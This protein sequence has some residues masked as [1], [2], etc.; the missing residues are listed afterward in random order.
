MRTAVSGTFSLGLRTNV[1][2]H[3]MAIGYIH[4]GTIAGKLN[5][6]MPAHTPIGSRMV[7]P[8]ISSAICGSDSPLRMCGMPQPNSTTSM[9]RAHV[10][11]RFFQ[12]L[13][14][15]ARAQAAQLVEV[16]RRCSS[17]N[18]EHDGGALGHGSCRTKSRT[19]CACGFDGGVYFL[20]AAH[21]H[22][23]R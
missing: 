14:V 6:V 3:A 12:R 4:S 20:R 22:A 2:P 8:S 23:W 5:G 18:R 16:L 7:T 11:L 21:R 10:A 17:R 1:F 13:A 15:L 9:P 19:P